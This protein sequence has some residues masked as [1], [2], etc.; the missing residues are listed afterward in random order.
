MQLIFTKRLAH[1]LALSIT[2]M[3]SALAPQ[4]TEAAVQVDKMF[5]DHMVLQRDL[6]VPIWGQAE[7]GEQVTVTFRKQTKT[8][9]ASKDGRWLVKLDPLKVGQAATLTVK[10]SN[11]ITFK[12]VLV[13]EVWVGSGQS[14]MAGGAGGYAKNDPVLAKWIQGG[15]YPNLR[16]YKGSWAAAD[17]TTISRFSAIH[18]SFGFRLH[19]ELKVPVGLMVGAVGGT[20]SGRWL[21]RE[22]AQADAA[23]VSKLQ[24]KDA[25]DLEKAKKIYAE[26][27]TLWQAAA[28]KAKAE[29]KRAPRKP[30]G[31]LNVGDLYERHV[32]PFVP[33]GIRGVLWDQ[34]E[35]KTQLPG[36][37]QYTTMNALIKGW[38]KVWGQGDFFFLHV[39]KP[40]GGGVAYDPENP[41]NLSAVKIAKPPASHVTNAMS[42]IYPL[43]HIKI[44]TIKNAPL[45]I[46]TDLAP[47]IHP[48]T[49]SAYGHRA[50]R[51]ALGAVYGQDVVISGP[52]YKSHKVEGASI[53]VSF[54]HVGKGL[55]FK[56]AK[57]IQGFE[58]AG[59]DGKWAWAKAAIDGNSI[60]LTSDEVKAPTQVQYA[61]NRRFNYANLFNKDGLP[62]LMFTTNTK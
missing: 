37:D 23:L 21:S 12:D 40:S 56:H 6:N 39:Q 38:R 57:D 43:D 55:D 62:A 34:G 24:P 60:V 50:C 9:A 44:G 3:L 15:P 1:S 33:Y 28:K 53:R 4:S 59:K 30:R 25:L 16:L 13:G 27:V 29:G 35:S 2:V 61:F 19:Q 11:T 42:L 7:P 54:N 17:K 36:V 46:A 5:S 48:R 14:N 18:F 26:K 32:K 41:I 47:G 20:P 31:P 10:A 52:T 58:I 49:K 45:V 51:V 22:M 8:A